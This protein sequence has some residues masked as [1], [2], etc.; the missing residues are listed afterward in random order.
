MILP[1]QQIKNGRDLGGLP[2][3][4]NKSVRPG[5]LLRSGTLSVAGAEDIRALRDDYKLKAIIDLRDLSEC[6]AEP[7][8]EIPGVGYHQLPILAAPTGALR[9]EL[10]AKLQDDPAGAFL[11]IYRDLAENPAVA[12]AYRK[13][14]DLVLEHREAPLLY[15]CHQGKD[16]TGIASILLLTSLGTPDRAIRDDYF[17]TN[18]LLKSDFEALEAQGAGEKQLSRAKNTLF[19]QEDC[20]DCYLSVLKANWGGVSGYLKDGV[21]L[22][23]EEIA[24]LRAAYTE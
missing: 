23:R 3:G 14:F 9:D 1:F 17:L 15:H 4:N 21:G 10:I 12:V 19:V 6:E 7:D 24:A 11:L 16:R 18:E 20:L 13:F 2:A 5:L 8:Q 22:A